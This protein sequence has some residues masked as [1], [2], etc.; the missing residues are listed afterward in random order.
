MRIT[1]EP[2]TP[3]RERS[4]GELVS[5]VLNQAT[6]LLRNEV[7]LARAE[8]SD[9]VSRAATG[10]AMLGAALAFGIATLVLLLYT[11]AVILAAVGVP[12]SVAAL[13]ATIVGAGATGALAWAG[14]KRLEADKLLPE[15]TMRQ[16]RRDRAVVK[17]ELQ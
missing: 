11:I 5:D 13:L 2:V 3:V 4:T 9:A 14:L 6:A 12:D 15:R 17:E 7:R 16:L 10:L 8:A 1:E